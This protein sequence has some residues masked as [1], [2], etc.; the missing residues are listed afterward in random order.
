MVPNVSGGVPNASMR[1]DALL[2]DGDDAF[3]PVLYA[4]VCVMNLENVA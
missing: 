4:P 3:C 1:R 2:N